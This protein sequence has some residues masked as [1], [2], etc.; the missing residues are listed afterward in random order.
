[1]TTLVQ[2]AQALFSETLAQG[3]PASPQGNALLQLV[4][5][6]LIFAV[7]YFLMILPQKKKMQQEQKM[8]QELKR[9]DEIYTKSGII[10]VI[11]GLT[12]K[13]V[14]LE[15]ASGVKVK[16]LRSQIGGSSDS[17]LKTVE[18]KAKA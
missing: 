1:M 14:T 6:V 15:I 8:L 18:K 12:D 7:F 5:M 17:V 11:E 2:M 4:P 10:G 16:Y 9:G 3:S 13:V